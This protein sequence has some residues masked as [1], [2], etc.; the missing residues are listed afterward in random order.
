MRDVKIGYYEIMGA[1]SELE[2]LRKERVIRDA[3]IQFK[4]NAA[5]QQQKKTLEEKGYI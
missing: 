3:D 5:W 2:R 1:A 4:A